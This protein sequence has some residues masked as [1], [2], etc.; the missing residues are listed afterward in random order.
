MQNNKFVFFGA[1]EGQVSVEVDKRWAGAASTAQELADLLVL[2][3]VDV[4]TA[5]MYFSSSVDFASEEGFATDSCA[6]DIIDAALDL[7]A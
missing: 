6:H 5:T 4:N 3:S 1:D 7:A 2:H